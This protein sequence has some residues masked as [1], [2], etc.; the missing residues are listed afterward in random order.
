M[1]RVGTVVACA[2]IAM[3]TPARAS[4]LSGETVQTTYFFP[5]LS[6]VFCGSVNSVVGAGTELPGYCFVF[7][8]DF[9]DTNITITAVNP[10]GQNNVAFDGFRFFDVNSTIPD[11]TGVAV[12][13]A[14]SYGGA[15]AFT[16]SRVSFDANTLFVNVENLPGVVGQIISLDLSGPSVAVPEPSGVFLLAAGLVSLAL[17][18]IRR[19]R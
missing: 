18:R 4:L 1:T 2:V 9:S 7:A 12:N 6:T 16:S 17:L 14:T 19:G 10:P 13:A 8:V 5:N 3:V 15:G 11:I